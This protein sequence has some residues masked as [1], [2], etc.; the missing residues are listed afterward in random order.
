MISVRISHPALPQ[1]LRS[2]L[3]KMSKMIRNSRNSHQI[4]SIRMSTVQKKPKSG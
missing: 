3:R 2:S 1:P 4:Q